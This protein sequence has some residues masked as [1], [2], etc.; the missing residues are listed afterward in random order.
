VRIASELVLVLVLALA[1]CAEEEPASPSGH[2]VS[3]ATPTPS[4]AL[5]FEDVT[6]TCGIDFVH[7]A[8]VTPEKHLPETMGGGVALFDADEDGDLDA[9]FVQSG[10]LPLAGGAPDRFAYPAGAKRPT[11]KLYANDGRARFTDVT[12]K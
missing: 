4:A 2:V 11:N 10:P 1:A 12:A 3:R 6:A 9:Y 5:R 8:G 7:D